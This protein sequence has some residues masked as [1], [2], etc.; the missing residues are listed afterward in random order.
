MGSAFTRLCKTIYVQIWYASIMGTKINATI[1]IT[2]NVYG[3]EEAF[4]MV[5]LNVGS[6]LEII[7]LGKSA[8]KKLVTVKTTANPVA[9]KAQPSFLALL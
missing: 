7:T 3:D 2:F 4:A 9:M 8:R 1:D 5:R 6:V